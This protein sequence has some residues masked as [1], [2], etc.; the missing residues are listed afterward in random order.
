MYLF[1]Y[2]SVKFIQIHCCHGSKKEILTLVGS[3]FFF[4]PFPFLY[5]PVQFLLIL[6]LT[7]AQK[8]LKFITKSKLL[9]SSQTK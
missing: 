3:Y 7:Q 6:H 8:S 2:Y 4:N 5:A 1:I 9:P